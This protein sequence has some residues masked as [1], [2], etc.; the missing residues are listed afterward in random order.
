MDYPEAFGRMQGLLI[1]LENYRS[2]GN[3]D[4]VLEKVDQII[5]EAKEIRAAKDAYSRGIMEKIDAKIKELA[6]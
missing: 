6:Q 5:K 1:D 3:D 2:F 4:M